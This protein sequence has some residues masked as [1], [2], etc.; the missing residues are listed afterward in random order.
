MSAKKQTSMDKFITSKRKSKDVVEE[1]KSTPTKKTRATPAA[2]KPKTSSTKKPASKPKKDIVKSDEE[3]TKEA[4]PGIISNDDVNPDPFNSYEDFVG[5][6]GD[7][8]EPL[9]DYLK[10]SHFKSIYENVKKEYNTTTCYPPKELIFNAFKKASFDNI[11]AVIVGQDPYIKKN[12]AIGLCFSVPKT[13][14]CPPSLKN[15]YKALAKDPKVDF[16]E[17]KPVHGDLQS[18]A[19][20][21]ILMLNAALTV[22]EGKS[23]SHAKLGWQRFTNEVINAINKHKEGVIFL[24]WGGKALEICKDVNK[25]KHHVLKWGHPSPMAQMHQKFEDCTHFSEVNEI[26]KKEGKDLIDWNLK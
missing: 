1:T 17:P 15:I 11:K 20:Q 8:Q 7:W 19:D 2:K 9:K 26:L 24:C 6:L 12:E 18:W 10:T 5:H 4:T 25:S 14:R 3:E 21:G 23:F 22:R 16:K 13:T